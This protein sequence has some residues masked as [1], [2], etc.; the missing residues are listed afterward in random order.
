M[1]LSGEGNSNQNGKTLKPNKNSKECDHY[2]DLQHLRLSPSI[3]QVLRTY[4]KVSPFSLLSYIGS[5]NRHSILCSA[6]SL[7]IILD[8]KTFAISS[9]QPRA[10]SGEC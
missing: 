2:E 3:L 1:Q 4:G 5:L 6:H 7:P 9:I 10:G 8:G